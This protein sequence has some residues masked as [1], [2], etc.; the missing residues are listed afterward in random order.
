MGNLIRIWR[1][2]GWACLLLLAMSSCY[3]ERAG[4][5]DPLATNYNFEADIACPDGC[6]TYPELRL[7]F[8]HRWVEPDSAYVLR[9]DSTFRD[10][11]GQ[12]FRLSRIRFYWSDIAFLRPGG[13]ELPLLDSVQLPLVSETGDTISRYVRRN[14]VLVQAGASSSTATVG[15]FRPEGQ[16]SGFRSAFGISGIANRTAV[17]ALPSSLGSGFVLRQ[18]AGRMNF[19][20]DTGYVA[21]KIELFRDTIASDTIPVVLNIF[22]LPAGNALA[23]DFGGAFSLIEATNTL[24]TFRIDYRQ[25]FSQADVRAAPAVLS[26]QIAEQIPA[27]I[28][29]LRI[30]AEE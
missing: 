4:C 6:C 20:P 1:N 9:L 28:S 18:Q 7:R 11:R 17:N 3:E 8:E 22:D 10:A 13:R 14:F 16:V 29:L 21:I 26:R 12:A 15:P 24:V 27:S 25:W 2:L 19:G 30:E 5:L 23:Y